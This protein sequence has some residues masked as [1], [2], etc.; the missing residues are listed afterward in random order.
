MKNNIHIIGITGGSGSGKT[1]LCNAL[2]K[3]FGNDCLLKIEVDSYYNDLSHLSME[4]REKNNFDHPD[5]FD[6]ELLFQDLNKIKKLKNIKIPIYDYKTHT[7]KV[8]FNH[9]NKKYNIILLEGIF[10]LYDKNIR[11]MLTTSIFIDI[12]NNTRKKRRLDRDIKDRKRTLQS[13]EKQYTT[14]VEPMYLKYIKPTKKY[15]NIIIKDVSKSD[16]GYIKLLETISN[17]INE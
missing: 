1:F 8:E 11:K 14:T 17:Y 16:K 7:R 2:I 3:K 13:I 12:P 5:A 9:I 6:F 4:K 10:S 15:S